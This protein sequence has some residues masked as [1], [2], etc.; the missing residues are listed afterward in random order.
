MLPCNVIV[1]QAEEG[2][3]VKALD[4]AA[5][6]GIVGNPALEEVARAARE[7]LEKALAGL[8]G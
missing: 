7:R 4:P 6:L 1:Y 2:S 3:V 5:A 8:P